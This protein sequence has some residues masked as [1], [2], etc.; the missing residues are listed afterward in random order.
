MMSMTLDA[1]MGRSVTIDLCTG[2]QAF[3]FDKYESLQL[4]PNST[5]KLMKFIGEHSVSSK[6]P[7][8]Q[9]LK[10]PRCEAQLL[11]TKDLQGS[12]RFSYWRCKSDHGR[13][14]RFFE[15]LREKQFIRVL[16]PKE[17]VEL[18][19]N[20]QILNC[21]NCGA[22]IDLASGSACKHCGSPVSMLDMKQPQEMLNQLRGAAET[23]PAVPVQR[24]VDVSFTSEEFRLS[25]NLVEAGL[26]AFARWLTKSGR[27]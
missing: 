24:P 8:P 14:T 16:S 1:H 15:F 7:F 5:L 18:R 3:W 22:P 9:T 11:L 4:S 26:T 17:I 10:C 12:T 13:F 25:H 20:I 19:K 23:Q 27:F 21:S 6:A 2:C